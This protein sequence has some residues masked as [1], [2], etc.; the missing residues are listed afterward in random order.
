M[1]SISFEWSTFVRCCDSEAFFSKFFQVKLISYD[2]YMLMMLRCSVFVQIPVYNELLV[3]LVLLSDELWPNLLPESPAV[4]QIKEII[5]MHL[6][7]VE[8]AANIMNTDIICH[9]RIY[10]IE[11]CHVEN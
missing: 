1:L 5:E 6:S 8:L 7:S 3:I 10:L 2:T 4:C 9:I 11:K